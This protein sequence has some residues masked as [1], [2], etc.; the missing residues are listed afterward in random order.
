MVFGPL[1][2]NYWPSVVVLATWTF[3]T[4]ASTQ[5]ATAVRSGVALG[6]RNIAIPHGTCM[7][8]PFWFTYRPRACSSPISVQGRSEVSDT[9]AIRPI[10]ATM[11][12]VSVDAPAMFELL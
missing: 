8:P 2:F 11:K 1:G 6:P 7:D 3:Q 4:G 10:C 9:I 5:M 12:W